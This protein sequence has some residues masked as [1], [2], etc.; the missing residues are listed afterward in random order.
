MILGIDTS[1]Y[2][3]SVSMVSNGMIVK[4]IRKVLTVKQGARGLRQS[5]AFYQHMENLPQLMD[6][7]GVIRPDAIAVSVAPRKVEGSYMPCFKAGIS[8][9][10]IL[11]RYLD[12]S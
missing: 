5:E 10:R 4:D 7:L 1:N 12:L 9:A 3:T 11:S 2:T 6:E 8:T